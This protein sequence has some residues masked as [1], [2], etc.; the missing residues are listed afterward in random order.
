MYTNQFTGLTIT[1][2]LEHRGHFLL[3]ARGGNEENYARMWAFPGGRNEAG[4]TIVDTIR[5]EVPEETSLCLAGQIGFLNTYGFASADKS[6]RV[7]LAVLVP[8]TSRHVKLSDENTNCAWVASLDDLT[9]YR[10]IPGIY[11]H[12][13]DALKFIQA[14]REFQTLE[15]FNLVP[16]KY[17][18]S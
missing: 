17:L 16:S 10:C 6:W 3:V 1:F 5:R 18:N 11:N 15:D 8:V 13:N 2:V 14:G 12:L 7:G 4:E 9:L